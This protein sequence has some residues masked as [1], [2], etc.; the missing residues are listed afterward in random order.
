PAQSLKTARDRLAAENIFILVNHYW[1]FFYDWQ[2]KA[3]IRSM[4]HWHKLID[5]LLRRDDL[6]FTTFAKG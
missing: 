3:D 5:D 1:T 4:Q 6:R 2:L